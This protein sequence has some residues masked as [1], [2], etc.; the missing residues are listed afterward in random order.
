MINKENK[1]IKQVITEKS[2]GGIVDVANMT[3][4][5]HLMIKDKDS[6]KVLVNRRG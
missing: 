3:V 2:E 4:Q 5:C 6:G 1:E